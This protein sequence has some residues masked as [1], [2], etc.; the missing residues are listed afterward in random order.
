MVIG[1]FLGDECVAAGKKT[2]KNIADV[3]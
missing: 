1:A 2:A 3:L